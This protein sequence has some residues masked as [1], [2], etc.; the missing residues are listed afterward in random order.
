MASLWGDN[1]L[2]WS[3]KGAL[4]SSGGFLIMWRKCLFGLNFSFVGEGFIGVNV[5][6]KE[7]NIHLVNMYSSSLTYN[8]RKVGRSFVISKVDSLLGSCV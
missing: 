3:F 1:D 2:E 4:G 5:K 6:W 8:K 7:L